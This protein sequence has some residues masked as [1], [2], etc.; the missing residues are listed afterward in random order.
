MTR[1]LL[2]IAVSFILFSFLKYFSRVHMYVWWMLYRY[3]MAVSFIGTSIFMFY[4]CVL[5]SLFIFVVYFAVTSII[6]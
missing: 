5:Q 6:E 3:F 2:G 4:G 1:N